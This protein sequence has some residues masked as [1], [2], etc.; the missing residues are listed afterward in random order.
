MSPWITQHFLNPAL[1]W[2]GLALVSIPIVIHLLNRLHYRRVR[3]AAMEFLLASQ[4]RN[5]RR[6]L[7]EQLL[8]LLLR[9]LFVLL[10][11]ALIGRMVL[12]AQQLSLFRGA[13]SHHLVLLDDSLSMRDRTGE[14]TAFDE[15]KSIIRK[16]V[17]EGANRPGTQRLTLLLASK[18]DEPLAGL[19]ARDIDDVLVDE[20]TGRLEDL[21]CSHQ[22]VDLQSAVVAAQHR[23]DS[24]RDDLRYLHILSDF[25]RRDWHDSQPMTATLRALDEAGIA[26]NLVRTVAADHENLAISDLN[27]NVA[28]AAA[29]VPVTFDV[30]VANYGGQAASDVRVTLA[31]DGRTLPK[32]L[33]FESIA[34][35]QEQKQS[36]E[37]RFPE[38]GP[39][40]LTAS[41]M[42]DALEPDNDRFL[43]VPVPNE[44]PV[45]IIDGSKGQELGTYIADALAADKSVTGYA[46]FVAAPDFLRQTSLDQ[47]Q[48]ISMVDVADL[49]P[50]DVAALERYVSAG[51][52]LAWFLGDAVQPA[53]YNSALY[54]QG[55]GLF[56]A[57]LGNAPRLLPR[58]PSS[59]AGPDIDPAVHPLMTILTGDGRLFLDLIFVNASYPV[60][61]QWLL[62]SLPDSSQVTMIAKLRSGQPLLLE[63]TL[64][65][66]RIVTCLTAAGPLLT[67]DGLP[68]TNW[69][70]GP[71]APSYAVFQLDLAKR[72]ARRDRELPQ[73]TVGE[74]IEQSFQRGQFSDEIEFVSPD[75]RVTQLRA[76]AKE[77]GAEQ[78]PTA[79]GAIAPLAASFRDTDA[80][81]IYSVRLTTMDGQ[82]QEQLIAYNVPVAEGDL[83]L[84][85]DSELLA[86]VGPVQ[87]LTIQPTGAF[88]WIRSEAPGDDIRWGLL[89]LLV[90]VIIGEQALAYRLSYHPAGPRRAAAAA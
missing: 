89:A 46:P 88:D 25:R 34:N 58:D 44:N 14:T 65:K 40:R 27:G 73:R 42:P 35:G 51:G 61:E 85:T 18:P 56:P 75:G 2:P 47:Y 43:A 66:G 1:F 74:P 87:Q 80:P 57:P 81:G 20:V 38:A 41:L 54:K 26:V 53:F 3:F 7:F 70:N 28:V 5:R 60:D 4:E 33:V 59:N 15:A 24:D 49:P 63:H 82:P 12:S 17:A 21:S 48:F 68:W 64:G 83:K 69:A 37:V 77:A 67:P 72:I 32:N 11:V 31:V 52:G 86:A 36:F 76:V 8:L 71:A 78:E 90:G 39:H 50:D 55:A 13:K 10:L 79:A 16:L 62:Q 30:T 9:I 6:V 19:A 84:V 23:L 22:A 29:G 45:L